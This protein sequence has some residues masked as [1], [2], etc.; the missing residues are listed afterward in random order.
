MRRPEGAAFHLFFVL[1]AICSRRNCLVDPPDTP[2]AEEPIRLS[3]GTEINPNTVTRAEVEYVARPKASMPVIVLATVAV[4]GVAYLARDVIVPAVFALML[5][6]LLRPLLRRTKHYHVPNGVSAL[7]LVGVVVALYVVAILTLAGQA[8]SWL[9]EAPQT[10]RNV[11][12]MLPTGKGPIDD[13]KETSEAMEEL[14]SEEGSAKPPEYKMAPANSQDF[15]YTALGVSGHFIG[16]SMI[17]F[18]LAYFLLALSD[19]LLKQM[20]EAM[21]SFFEKRNVV[22]LVQNVEKGMS[23]YLATITVVNIGLGIVTAFM[24]WLLDLPNP[25]LWG[26]M[27][28]VLNYVPHVG[29]FLMLIVLFFVGSLAHESLWWGIVAGGTF[30]LITTAESYFITPL[31]LS[32]SL[33]LSPL[34]VILSI[35]IFGWLWGIGGGLLAAPL[36]AVIKIVCDQFETLQPYSAILGVST[37]AEQKTAAADDKRPQQQAA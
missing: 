27:A 31:M 7:V 21:P 18:V 16:S 35:L 34:A 8:Q 2:A 1:S 29:A 30:A 37:P 28:T 9:A 5:A 15:A 11:K 13:I 10:I 32:R 23:R 4:L 24:M 25:I 17:V 6:L 12:N 20:V 36:L 19:Q 33:E 3:D 22:Q 14:T 26:V